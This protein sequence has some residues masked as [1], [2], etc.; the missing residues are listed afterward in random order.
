MYFSAWISRGLRFYQGLEKTVLKLEEKVKEF[1]E[2]R[3][4]EMA[5][6]EEKEKKAKGELQLVNVQYCL[7]V[8]CPEKQLHVTCYVYTITILINYLCIIFCQSIK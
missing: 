3:K 8:L 1:Y 4:K 7:Q 2:N 6:I 5:K